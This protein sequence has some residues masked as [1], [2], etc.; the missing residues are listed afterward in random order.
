MIAKY[1]YDLVI[2]A[3]IL[4]IF[5]LIKKCQTE[6]F[7][8][9]PA[10]PPQ[11]AENEYPNVI[12]DLK[13]KYL[14][15]YQDDGL[16]RRLPLKNGTRKAVSEMDEGV[17]K[18]IRVNTYLNTDSIELSYTRLYGLIQE[19]VKNRD[20][21]IEFDSDFL[22]KKDNLNQEYVHDT[23]LDRII[24]LI[25]F[26]YDEL[27]LDT[28]Y[29]YG[30]S[31]KY[32]IKEHQIIS[33]TEVSGLSEDNRLLIVNLTFYKEDK[34]SHFT[35]QIKCLYN[36][37][38][39]VLSL[40]KIDIIGIHE[41]EK[42]EFKDTYPLEQK[43]CILDKNEG[44]IPQL[45]YCH[46]KKLAENKR[47]LALFEE[48]FNKNELEKFYQDKEDAKKRDREFR[49]Y[50]CFLKDG[51]SKSSCESYSFEK[52]TYGVWDKPCTNNEECPFYKQNKNYDNTRGG[53]INGYCEMPSNIER[54]GYH[55]YD[56]TYKPYCHN[57]DRK[58][59]LGDDCFTCCE[60]QMDRNK[61]PKLKSPDYIFKNDNRK[62]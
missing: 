33:D 24:Q 40:E 8:E 43:H 35:I 22:V 4:I 2:L 37:I 36:F 59:C 49:K 30:D 39:N 26:Y 45:S 6:K 54:I 42:I 9:A 47:S 17:L 52:K 10:P 60:E 19:L 20:Y 48:E 50:K 56:T 51:F 44:N 5:Y 7:A 28:I 31:R 34:D 41:N 18:N 3:I 32:K 21:E 25:N 12:Q 13:D 16:Y 38:Q 11:L 29:N 57:C 62:L 23:I 58:N 14:D 55:Y 27:G 46:P 1:V 61:Y 15:T 53:C